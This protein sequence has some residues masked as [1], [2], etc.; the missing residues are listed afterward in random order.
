ME[1]G[2][3]GN[4][5]RR[6]KYQAYQTARSFKS[7]SKYLT[8]YRAL[9]RRCVNQPSSTRKT[10]DFSPARGI[11]MQKVFHSRDLSVD[12]DGTGFSTH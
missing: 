10:W 6:V 9:V 11:E 8:C 1:R 4:N 2:A 3:N 7:T 12:D 5:R